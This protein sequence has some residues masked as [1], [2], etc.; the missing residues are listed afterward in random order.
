MIY[1]LIFAFELILLFILSQKLIKAL[2]KIIYKFTRSHRVTVHTLAIIFLPGTIIHE[3]AHLLF[4]GVMLVPLGELSVLPEI[5]EKGVK[6]GRMQ[7]GQTD[8]LRRMVI[9][10]A[11]VLLG[12]ILIFSIF[13]LVKIGVS[14]WWQ[15]FLALYFIFQIGNTMFSSRKDL[16]GV[17]GFLAI[18]AALAM[19]LVVLYFFNQALIQQIW[20]WLN[21]LDLEVVSNFFKTA[22]IY[23]I[24]PVLL[25]LSIILLTFLGAPGRNRTFTLSSEAT[26]SIH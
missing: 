26:R 19:V 20:L 15:V 6:L 1:F 24:L 12:M 18:V 9:G 21:T 4:A 5:E 10:V 22:S 17:V 25:D 23:L 14:P 7:I 13:F 8:P 3:L 16:E 2:A 11:P